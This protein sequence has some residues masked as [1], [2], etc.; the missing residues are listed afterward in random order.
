M[1][2]YKTIK[3]KLAYLVVVSVLA[4]ALPCFYVY[5]S[6]SRRN[7]K[8]ENQIVAVELL[9]AVAEFA[10]CVYLKDNKL[11]FDN[12]KM[13]NAAAQLSGYY[14]SFSSKNTKV[15][16]LFSQSALGTFQQRKM[17]PNVVTEM[18]GIITERAS[19]FSDSRTGVRVLMET[20]GAAL[21]S[22]F[23]DTVALRSF[24]AW[25]FAENKSAS[26]ASGLFS[27]IS[28][29]TRAMNYRLGNTPTADDYKI[30]S[31]IF[32]K[33]NKLNAVITRME[34]LLAG[35]A[36][37]VSTREQILAEVDSFES[38]IFE[39]WVLANKNLSEMLR[40]KQTLQAEAQTAFWGQFA[41][42]LLL[43]LAAAGFIYASIVRGIS[44]VSEIVSLAASGNVGGAREVY[45]TASK[46]S[47]GE[48]NDGL[49]ALVNYM[50]GLIEISENIAK[51]SNRLSLMLKG[52]EATKTPLFI[53]IKDTFAAANKQIKGDYDFVIQETQKLGDCSVV[54]SEIEKNLKNARKSIALFRE[55]MES[56]SGV[57]NSVS[58]KLAECRAVFGKVA[59]VSE[60]FSDAADKLNLLGLNLSVIASKLGDNSDGVETLAA[61]IRVVSRQIAV[62]VM[63]MGYAETA[64]SRIISETQSDIM[65]II[66]SGDSCAGH[67]READAL[68]GTSWVSVSG[69][70][71]VVASVFSSLRGKISPAYDF[72]MS[73][74]DLD[75]IKDSISDMSQIVKKASENVD[76][77]RSKIGR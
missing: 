18:A 14:E 73:V 1:S 20:S 30:D 7:D 29:Q 37:G 22:V 60:A 64:I 72:D 6:F 4:T 28:I 51:I 32:E 68:S 21:P 34:R 75:D 31:E 52:M 38:A 23:S 25:L 45:E 35:Y 48:I 27:R 56:I 47:F 36:Q 63:D 53:A 70:G 57:S 65:Q 11:P 41:V 61:Q 46:S 39:M 24:L 58:E 12:S 8:C 74:Q 5:N 16:S 54:V 62:S 26:E 33:T 42:W 3:A 77:L 2:I 67:S 10:N 69:V 59:A 13:R 15:K 71:T 44:R 76:A 49:S 9:D 43:I 19:L 50:G 40:Y 66:K 55:N 17:R